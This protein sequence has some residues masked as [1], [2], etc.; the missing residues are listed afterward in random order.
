MTIPAAPLPKLSHLLRGLTAIPADGRLWGGSRSVHLYERGAIALAAAAEAIRRRSGAARIELFLPD[1]ICNEALDWLR[2]SATL[3]FYRLRASL[4]PEWSDVDPAP[5]S[6]VAHGMVIVHYFGFPNPALRQRMAAP[7]LPLIEDSAHLLEPIPATGQAPLV[8]YSPRK[9]LSIPSAGCLVSDSAYAPFAPPSEPN[10]T[11]STAWVA[12][13]LVQRVLRATHLPWHWLWPPQLP[14]SGSARRGSGFSAAPESA[15][16]LLQIES[17]DLDGVRRQRRLNYLRLDGYVKQSLS[18]DAWYPALP[19]EVCPYAY[20]VRVPRRAGTLV[21]E[22]RRAGIPAIRWPDLPPEI[23]AERTR[24]AVAMALSEQLVV[25]PIHQ[26]LTERDVDQI[27]A[28]LLR[29]ARNI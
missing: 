8:V 9:L 24:H 27:G 23:I 12:R 22:L 2:A 13:R 26:S 4:E 15:R 19:E 25:L 28:R 21:S 14:E 16:R 17:E 11:G 6:A 5:A 3:R 7:D 18:L 10:G 1:F 29:L 20:P